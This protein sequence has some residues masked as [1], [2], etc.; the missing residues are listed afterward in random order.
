M[1]KVRRRTRPSNKKINKKS[2]TKIKTP[3]IKIKTNPSYIRKAI[4]CRG[5][6][7][8]NIPKE[9]SQKLQLMGANVKLVI[10]G[11]K[12]IISKLNER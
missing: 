9:V 4:K 3:K 6:V 11:K 7:F 5:S 8:V 2:S 1:K 12:L 10:N